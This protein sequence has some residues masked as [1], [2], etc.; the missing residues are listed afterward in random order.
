MRDRICV[1][2]LDLSQN[3]DLIRAAQAARTATE[4][5]TGNAGVLQNYAD[6]ITKGFELGVY[7]DKRHLSEAIACVSHA[8]QIN[9]NYPKYH[10]TLGRLLSFEGRYKEAVVS[11]QRAINLENSETKDSFI[12]I[13][14]Y[15]RHITDIKLRQNERK[16]KKRLYVVAAVI[17]MQLVS[18]CLL[19]LTMWRLL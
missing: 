1:V 13:M 18:I 14:E 11:I 7:R 3:E 12:R 10:C 15:N 17:G 2:N 19:W 4:M 6:L 5:I 16:A 8:L 9:P